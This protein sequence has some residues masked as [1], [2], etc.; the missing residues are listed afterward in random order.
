MQNLL[1]GSNEKMFLILRD[2]DSS[3]LAVL[4]SHII[5]APYKKN[6]LFSINTAADVS[7][8]NTK[9]R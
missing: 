3:S 7:E 1:Q 8:I 6:D 5:V 4:H 2:D 9:K